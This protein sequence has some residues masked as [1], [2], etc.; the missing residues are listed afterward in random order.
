LHVV[1]HGQEFIIWSLYVS[2][3][4]L[5]MFGHKFGHQ[6]KVLTF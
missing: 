5:L 2:M 6:L 3:A 4:W 1:S